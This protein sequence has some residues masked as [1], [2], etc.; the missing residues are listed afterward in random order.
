MRRSVKH[1]FAMAA[2]LAVPLGLLVAASP[3]ATAGTGI[4]ATFT[5]TQD[6][7]SGYEASYTITNNTPADL[8][9]WTATQ[10]ASP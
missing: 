5:K 1:L 8:S 3:G 6:W 4:T 9:G 10:S 7:G 2:V